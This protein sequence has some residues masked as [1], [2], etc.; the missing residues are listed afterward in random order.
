VRITN[1]NG[2]VGTVSSPATITVNPIPTITRVS[3]SG[4]ASQSVDLIKAITT[5]VYTAS[6]DATISKTGN[7][8]PSG[9]DGNAVGSSYTISGTPTVTG[10]FGYSLTAAVGGCTGTASV[11]TITVVT[12][13][14]T[15][16]GAA[17]TSTWVIG[18]Q[19]WS[20]PLILRPS[21]CVSVTSYTADNPPPTGHYRS[22]GLLSGSG[23][24]YNWKC[25]SDYAAVLC[26]SPW[27]VPTGN[28]FKSLDLALGGTGSA[29][30]D[31][32]DYVTATYVSMWGA[33][34]GGGVNTDG[35]FYAKGEVAW[36][37]SST[38][39]SSA[40]ARHLTVWTDGHVGP[41]EYTERKWRLL[42]VRCV[43]P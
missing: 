32:P 7:T 12:A 10:T 30:S 37:W 33:V 27:R 43:R 38:E 36:Y 1:S 25:V 6:N 28:D 11:G 19:F 13:V 21:G 34:F 31:T 42:Q 35:S 2:C 40:Y 14:T 24:L 16:S 9:L 29:R 20:A 39:V 5:I 26:P 22:S 18:D 15:P 3:S 8:F 41:D 17:S 23:Y 4:S